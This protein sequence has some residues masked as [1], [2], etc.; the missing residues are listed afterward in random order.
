MIRAKLEVKYFNTPIRPYNR[1]K[2]NGD[3]FLENILP[4]RKARLTT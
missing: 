3:F 1:Q 2:R 4:K